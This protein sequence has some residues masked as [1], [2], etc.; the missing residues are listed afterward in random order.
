MVR[1]V[2][3]FD[4]HAE[5]FGLLLGKLRQLDADLFE[6]QA[7]DFFVQ[8]LGQTINGRFVCCRL[9]AQ[10]S[11]CARTWLVKEFD[12]TKLGWPSAQPRFTSRP[13]ASR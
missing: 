11:S 4:G 10:R 9:F 3:A 12:I 5:V 2:R 8:L 13:S 7:G 1:L 6:V